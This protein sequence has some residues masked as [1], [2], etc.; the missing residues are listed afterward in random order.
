MNIQRRLTEQATAAIR[1]ARQYGRIFESCRFVDGF[2]VQTCK[3]CGQS[4]LGYKLTGMPV[5]AYTCRCYDDWDDDLEPI[6]GNIDE[7]MDTFDFDLGPDDHEPED[8]SCPINCCDSSLDQED[9]CD[10]ACHKA[11]HG[12]ESK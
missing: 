7:V 5:Q 8:Y 11:M 3:D 1:L 9:E 12:G 6:N 4:N 10:C 2:D